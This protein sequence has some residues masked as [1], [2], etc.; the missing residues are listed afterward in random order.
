MHEARPL[1]DV[2]LENVTIRGLSEVSVLTPAPGNPM[3][4][5]MKNVEMTWRNG[6]P[7]L[8]MFVTTPDVKLVLDNVKIEGFNS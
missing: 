6:I 7:A 2:T 3:T 4:F 5:T 1:K 8:G